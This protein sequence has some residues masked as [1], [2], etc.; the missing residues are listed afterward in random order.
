MGLKQDTLITVVELTSDI[1]LTGREIPPTKEKK[2]SEMTFIKFD[3][4]LAGLDVDPSNVI[5]SKAYKR[6]KNMQ[7]FVISL[8]VILP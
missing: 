3:P 6:K 7:S 1:Y 4:S 5:P 8:I 2:R